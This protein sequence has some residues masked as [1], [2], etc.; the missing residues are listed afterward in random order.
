MKY[1]QV[2]E[3]FEKSS[4]CLVVIAL[5]VIGLY[6]LPYLKII[7]YFSLACRHSSQPSHSIPLQVR[8][9][10]LLPAVNLGVII[11]SIFVFYGV[12]SWTRLSNL[13]APFYFV[14]FVDRTIQ[15]ASI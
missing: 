1:R 6:W 15:G 4:V 7:E 12:S 13:G 10:V 5:G 9:E 14:G 3:K 8:N 11:A 2:I